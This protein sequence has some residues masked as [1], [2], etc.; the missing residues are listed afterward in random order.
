MPHALSPPC[1][2][3]AVTKFIAG[4]AGIASAANSAQLE[5]KF[6][7]PNFD[8]FSNCCAFYLQNCGALDVRLALKVTCLS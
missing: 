8:L 2:G 6:F 5:T 3:W 7:P 4:A 1:Q